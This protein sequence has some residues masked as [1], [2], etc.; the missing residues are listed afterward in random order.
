L[1]KKK[2]VIFAEEM[3]SLKPTVYRAE[4]MG[5]EEGEAHWS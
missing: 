3:E 4:E 2:L 5:E 1:Q